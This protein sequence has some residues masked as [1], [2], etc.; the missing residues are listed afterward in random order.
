MRNYLNPAPAR[1][2][3]FFLVLQLS[4]IYSTAQ[5]D[6]KEQEPEMALGVKV[7]TRQIKYGK[8]DR[9]ITDP[10]SIGLQPVL[11][12]DSPVK[13][14]A[15]SYIDLVGQAGFLFC[16]ANGFDTTYYDPAAN[17]FIREH[18]HNPAYLPLYFGAYTMSALSLGAEIFY[19]KGLGTRDIW[20]VKFL[21]LGYKA[22]QFRI[23]VAGELYAQVRDGKKSGSIISFDFFL[24]L[25]NYRKQ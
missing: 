24:K 3:L 14:G 20:G 19:W 12:Y 8:N 2:I 25:I 4:S 9:F 17:T 10:T 7:V 5:H 16:K 13:T 23:A 6:H 18:S 11:R 15:G 1:I 21:S 22:K